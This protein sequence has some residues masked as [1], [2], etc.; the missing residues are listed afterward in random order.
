MKH[1]LEQIH[2]VVSAA[3]G[4][5]IRAAAHA[6]GMT[7]QALVR[8]TLAADGLLEPEPETITE[9]VIQGRPRDRR[10]S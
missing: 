2:T 3:E 6:R 4:D 8:R 10:S 5:A 1:R 7:V 9:F